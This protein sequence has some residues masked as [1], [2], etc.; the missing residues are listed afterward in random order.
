MAQK[1][2]WK[3]H[4]VLPL[5]AA[6]WATVEAVPTS[7]FTLANPAFPALAMAK[8][9]NTNMS[10]YENVSNELHLVHMSAYSKSNSGVTGVDQQNTQSFATRKM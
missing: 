4:Q 1:H 9:M 7:C 10:E 8:P 3:Y 2:Q 6:I 5:D